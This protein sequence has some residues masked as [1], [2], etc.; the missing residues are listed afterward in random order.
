MKTRGGVSYFSTFI[1][2]HYKKLW[3]YALKNKD[4][5]LNVFKEFKV[6]VER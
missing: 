1:D 6:A 3:V 5:E 2:D 4:Q